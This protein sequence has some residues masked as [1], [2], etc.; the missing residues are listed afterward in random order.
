[1]ERFNTLSDSYGRHKASSHDRKPGTPGDHKMKSSHQHRQQRLSD[2]FG[3]NTSHKGHSPGKSNRRSDPA[4]IPLGVHRSCTFDEKNLIDY[5]K[6][7]ALETFSQQSTNS[8]QSPGY[9]MKR[10]YSANESDQL[11]NGDH[12]H[13][14]IKG[15]DVNE[16]TPESEKTTGKSRSDDLSEDE[17]QDKSMAEANDLSVKELRLMILREQSEWNRE[18][19]ELMAQLYRLRSNALDHASIGSF[20]AQDIKQTELERSRSNTKP[21]T[22]P[23]DTSLDSAVGVS[24]FMPLDSPNNDSRNGT[25]YN[26][27]HSQPLVD[28]VKYFELRYEKLHE[29]LKNLLKCRETDLQ[30]FSRIRSKFKIQK[31]ILRDLISMEQNRE[32]KEKKLKDE[33][34]LLKE[35]ISQT[36]KSVSLSSEQ[37][38]DLQ[39]V[40]RKQH[41]VLEQQARTLRQLSEGQSLQSFPVHS[42]DIQ[43]NASLIQKSGWMYLAKISK[44]F[45]PKL[46]KLWGLKALAKG[47][48]FIP[49]V[50]RNILSWHKIYASVSEFCFE[51]FLQGYCFLSISLNKC[52]GIYEKL[53]EHDTEQLVVHIEPGEQQSM[54]RNR[55][56]ELR[57]NDHE[58]TESWRDILAMAAECGIAHEGEHS[59]TTEHANKRGIGLHTLSPTG[60]QSNHVTGI[61]FI[62]GFCDSNSSENQ[63]ITLALGG[64]N[65]EQVTNET[66]DKVFSLNVLK[67]PSFSKSFILPSEENK[68]TEPN[69]NTCVWY[70]A[71]ACVN[72]WTY[73]LEFYDL[74]P[75]IKL[76]SK[77]LKVW[78]QPSD[79]WVNS[80]AIGLHSP[81]PSFG[82]GCATESDKWHFFQLSHPGFHET[83]CQPL[84]RKKSNLLSPV[85][86]RTTCVCAVSSQ[87]EKNK[88]CDAFSSLDK[89][90]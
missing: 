12:T 75:F 79:T 88:W 60:G 41:T 59:S 73:A 54:L 85:T 9:N 44:H 48:G 84:D 43:Q 40:V 82:P 49:E 1:M 77:G 46:E 37:I 80:S 90:G 14:V 57:G 26:G 47:K 74:K 20:E 42:S 25:M 13:A 23:W 3:Q 83:T 21:S 71:L 67:S 5:K 30:Q 31:D 86:R 81:H 11:E 17:Q 53:V 64:D 4:V 16:G 51:G 38:K 56:L 65:D 36:E 76:P 6:Q 66:E 68:D 15:K 32:E 55:A 72:S 2:S 8:H 27:D 63:L 69:S 29:Q 70:R 33:V 78:R 50:P 10:W 22:Y 35:R 61:V 34:E 89:K 18:N 39:S 62:R 28:V 7:D 58:D 87:E 24:D 19:Q 52:Q 45:L